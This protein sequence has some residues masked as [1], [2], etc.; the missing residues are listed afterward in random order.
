M[1]ERRRWSSAA[2]RFQGGNGMKSR[3]SL[4]F[5]LVAASAVLLASTA[6]SAV[7]AETPFKGTF[8]AVETDQL[9]FPILSVNR[10]GTGTATYLGKYTEHATLQVDVRTGSATGAATFTA[11]N[12]DTLTASVVGQG[13]P[14]GPTTRSIVEVYTITGGTGRF[15]DATGTLTLERTLDLTTGVSTGTFSGAIDH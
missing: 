15:A 1:V 6:V 12:G 7:A 13:T 8:S 9:V 11:A 10:E 14:T 2:D 5:A 4:Y 3:H